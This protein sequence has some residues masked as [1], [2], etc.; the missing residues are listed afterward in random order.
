VRAKLMVGQKKLAADDATVATKEFSDILTPP[1]SLGE[2]KHLLHNR[3]DV[4]FWLGEAQ[5][6]VGD[7]AGAERAYKRS[8][9]E[10]HD[11]QA[12]ALRAFS[13]QTYWSAM[14]LGRLGRSD[15]ARKLLEAMVKAA[16]TM[17]MEKP[18]ID[19]FA[20]SL[21]NLLLFDDDLAERQRVEARAQRAIALEGLG[22]SEASRILHDE[23]AQAD[24]NRIALALVR[25]PLQRLNET[26]GTRDSVG[27]R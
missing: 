23:V 5:A 27:T 13:E 2:A 16:E 25:K 18:V 20:T 9:R 15:D 21:P 24:P 26:M 10:L 6:A 4:Y 22:Q 19:Y 14:A 7:A 8:V 17:E 3:A 11:P 1:R 12:D